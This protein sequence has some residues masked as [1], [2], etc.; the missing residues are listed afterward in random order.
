MKTSVGDTSRELVQG[1][2]TQRNV[3]PLD[4]KGVSGEAQLPDK[5]DLNSL[6]IKPQHES[7]RLSFASFG[8]YGTILLTLQ[9]SAAGG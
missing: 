2:F 6:R 8:T 9:S 7:S 3:E 4:N 1:D 5:A